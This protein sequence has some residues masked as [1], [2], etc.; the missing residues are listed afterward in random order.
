[1]AKSECG[2][3]PERG[4]ARYVSTRRLSVGDE[5]PSVRRWGFGVFG[6]GRI[7][8]LNIESRET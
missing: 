5:T 6:G 1:M 7:G 4:M 2:I 3:D 8:R